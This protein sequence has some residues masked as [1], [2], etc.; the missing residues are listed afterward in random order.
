MMSWLP[1]VIGLHMG[2]TLLVNGVSRQLFVP[3][4]ELP[5]NLLGGLLGLGEIAIGLSFVYGAL[6][7]P[8]AAALALLWLAGVLLF[9]PIRLVEH[10][11]ILGVAVRTCGCSS[12]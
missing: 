7:R 9:G 12:S 2:V 11:E 4:L 1:L 3:N 6:A 5:V 8:A 10:T